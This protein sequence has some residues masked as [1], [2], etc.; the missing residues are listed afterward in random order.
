M[1]PELLM[2]LAPLVELEWDAPPSCP[3]QAVFEEAVRTQADVSTDRDAPEVLKTRVVIREREPARWELLLSMEREGELEARTLEA[4]TCAE[5]AQVAATLVSLRVVEWVEQAPLVPLPDSPQPTEPTAAP[6]M[7]PEPGSPTEVSEPMTRQ[8]QTLRTVAT[9]ESPTQ[10]PV[11]LG[12]WLSVLGGVAFGVAPG[13]GG[14]VAVEGGLKARWWRAGIGVQTAPRRLQPHPNDAGVRGRF[15]VV[16]AEAIG[17]GV[18]QAGPVEFP[19][20]GRLAAG[21]IRANAT[22]DVGR[23]EPAWGGWWGVGASVGA[24]WRVTDRLAPTLSVE[25]L[26]PLR[27]W[28]FSVGG[29]PGPLH[30]T[31]AVALRAWAG[32]E[33]HL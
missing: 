13:V 2:F 17:C 11:E 5:V 27:D 15:D 10:L 18:P 1:A 22:G 23:S 20:C 14:A 4:E 29:V 9:P 12:G 8:R 28:S 19:I 7:A 26:T 32:L 16:V 3:S 33:I 30:E 31:G 6:L 21:G 25:A 24:A